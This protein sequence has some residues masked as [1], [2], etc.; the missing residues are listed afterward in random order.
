MPKRT[1]EH[2]F[3][4]TADQSSARAVR[5]AIS[6]SFSAK[7]LKEFSKETRNMRM[8]IER[9]IKEQTK[10]G[11]DGI[12]QNK[13]LIDTV[14]DLKS[15]YKEVWE[16]KK[17]IAAEEREENRRQR[18][19]NKEE[20]RAAEDERKKSRVEAEKTRQQYTTSKRRSFGA[21][22]IQGLG[23]ADY[24]PTDPGMKA[25]LAGNLVGMGIRRAGGAATAP[26]INPGI[27]GLTQLIGAVPL[28][29]GAAAGAL[30]AASGMFG[31][32]VGLDQARLQNLYLM[33]GDPMRE[34]AAY[35]NAARNFK[36]L[37]DLK[38]AEINAQQARENQRI[39]STR[40]LTRKQLGRIRAQNVVQKIGGLSAGG[41][42]RVFLSPIAQMPTENVQQTAVRMANNELIAARQYN[43]Q[44]DRR[45]FLNNIAGKIFGPL[46]QGTTGQ[47]FQP[48]FGAGYGI[49]PEGMQGAISEFYGARGGLPH[50]QRNLREA[51]ALKNIFGIGYQQTGALGRFRNTG[52]RSDTTAISN[53]V[54]SAFIQG[55]RGSHMQ[56]YMQELVTQ[57]REAEQRGVKIDAA[58]FTRQTAVI[59]AMGVNPIQALR[60]TGGM[61]RMARDISQRGIQSPEQ[62][63]VMRA[64]GFDP[65]GGTVSYLRALENMEG[66][67][68]PESLQRLMGF[69]QQGALQIRG[70]TEEETTL[71]RRFAV[72]RFFGNLNIPI[73]AQIAQQIVESGM[74]TDPKQIETMQAS[75]KALNVTNMRELLDVSARGRTQAGAGLAVFQ[76]G[77]GAQQIAVGREMTGAFKD[78]NRISIET[79]KSIGNFRYQIESVTKAMLAMTRG[80]ER[81]T[82][83]NLW[84]N[85]KNAIF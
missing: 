58:D 9:F 8:E 64:A 16:E 47:I 26:F 61:N 10:S 40:E 62:F 32:A 45:N 41:G 11:R 34:G 14:K 33:G 13:E 37:Y 75:M 72:K 29:G 56:E 35:L 69:I 70:R 65:Q 50:D 77:I 1:S 80:I 67:F 4:I 2:S 54:A 82:R 52:A 49:T 38:Q 60:I 23:I 85:L 84:E 42:R 59:G 74:Q 36:P 63:L 18:E 43:E 81:L 39:S 55:F 79:A 19:E 27:S 71:R 20:R 46:M 24:F 6:E 51:L 73:G 22:L 44:E 28:I 5:R 25:R 68:T 76:A 48:G 12:A 53:I 15:A 57:G 83:G 78:L 21:G 31:R 66:Q 30:N 7:A 3:K 17:R